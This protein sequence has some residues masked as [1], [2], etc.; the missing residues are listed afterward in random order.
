MSDVIVCVGCHHEIDSTAKLCPYCGADPRSGTKVDTQAMLQEVFRPRPTTRGAGLLDFARNRQGAIVAAGIA[1]GF[2]ILAGLYQFVSRRND[3]VSAASAVP[4]TEITD[5][6][7]QGDEAKPLPMPDMQFQ[8]DGHPQTM[9]TYVV[10]PGAVPP[11][12]VAAAQQPAPQQ[13]RPP[14]K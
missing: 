11:P 13:Q 2:L 10:E 4:I 6:S 8:Y 14:A 3:T 5:L 9:R 1:I 12:E 7:D